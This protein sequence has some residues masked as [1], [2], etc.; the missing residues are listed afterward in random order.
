MSAA[1]CVVDDQLCLTVTLPASSVLSVTNR[2][3]LMIIMKCNIFT[4]LLKPQT[5]R[6]PA[7]NT[8]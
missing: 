2:P 4:A 3:S 6:F 5:D 7:K 1:V 8:S